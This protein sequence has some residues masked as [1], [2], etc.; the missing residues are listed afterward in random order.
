MPT[1]AR[2]STARA[3]KCTNRAPLGWKAGPVCSLQGSSRVFYPGGKP[4][5]LKTSQEIALLVRKLPLLCRN[6][7][8]REL[9]VHIFTLVLTGGILE[10]GCRVFTPGRFASSG[11]MYRG[12]LQLCPSAPEF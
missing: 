7:D 2:V 9:R 4:V 3:R 8:V 1:S 11:I 6:S 10:T 12:K 5:A